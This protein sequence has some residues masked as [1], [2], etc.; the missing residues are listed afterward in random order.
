M[1]CTL[2]TFI[3]TLNSNHSAKASLRL[4]GYGPGLHYQ[5]VSHTTLC[6]SEPP[7]N[8][9]EELLLRSEKQIPRSEKKTDTPIFLIYLLY[10]V[11]NQPVQPRKNRLS[12]RKNKYSESGKQILRS[13]KCRENPNTA[14]PMKGQNSTPVLRRL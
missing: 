13:R 8:R 1:Y 14:L 10:H 12:D 5:S 4:S 6:T 3:P 2:P 9:S 7:E 11:G